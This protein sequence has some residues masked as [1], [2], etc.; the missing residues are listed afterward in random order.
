[1]SESIDTVELRRR[2]HRLAEPSGGERRTASLLREV[3]DGLGPD[4]LIDGLGGRGLAAVFRGGDGPVVLVR[5][6]LDAVPIPESEGAPD[7]SEAAGYSHMCGHDGHMAIVVGLADSLSRRRTE[8][9][10]AVLLFQPAEETGAG[11]ARVLEEPRLQALQPDIA[12]ALHNVPGFPLGSVVLRDGVFASTAKSLRVDL[13]GRTSHAAE[14][15]R[16]VSPTAAVSE[17]LTAWPDV[18]G[19]VA[20]TGEFALVTV[21]HARVGEVALGTT[22]GAATV[23]ATLRAHSPDVM[24]RLS[25]RCEAIASDAARAHGLAMSSEWLEEFPC[26]INDPEA[27]SLVERAA[28]EAG[29][30]VVRMPEPFRW[31]EDFG[32]FTGAFGGAM[33]GLGAGEES[34]PLHHPQYVFPDELLPLG[35]SL[36]RRVIDAA[37]ATTAI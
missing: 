28:R 25:R 3:L 31:T 8:R 22:P 35:S 33:F 30:P 5:C 6:E 9:G 27:N 16:G 23:I 36:L 21:V 24:E 2:L 13:E 20:E 1:M 26:T 4:A 37:T 11:A 12:F 29:L 15:E 19:E 17:I 34:P 32:R 14:P 7:A 10:S 18:P